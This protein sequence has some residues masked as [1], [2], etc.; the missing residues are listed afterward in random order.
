M[1]HEYEIFKAGEKVIINTT[2][3]EY[4]RKID[5]ITSSGNYK[6]GKSIYNKNG[7]LRGAGD[8]GINYITKLTPE[9]EKRL[10]RKAKI[11]NIKN[12][13]KWENLNDTAINMIFDIIDK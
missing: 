11:Y 9:I 12:Y 2:Y 13:D 6:I 5:T 1:I 3:H 8:W 7:Q 10:I 4:I